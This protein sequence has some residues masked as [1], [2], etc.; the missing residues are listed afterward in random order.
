MLNL[1]P[2]N[3]RAA[4]CAS[5]PGLPF[6]P[7]PRG[8]RFPLWTCP[9]TDEAPLLG[10]TPPPP[11]FRLTER[12][13]TGPPPPADPFLHRKGGRGPLCRPRGRGARR[14]EKDPGGRRKGVV[15]LP[16]P[17][18]AGGRPIH[19]GWFPWQQEGEGLVVALPR[20][21][22]MSVKARRVPCPPLP[23]TDPAGGSAGPRGGGAKRRRPQLPR[24]SP[25]PRPRDPAHGPASPSKLPPPRP[26]APGRSLSCPRNKLPPVA[27]RRR[28]GREPSPGPP[29]ALRVLAKGWPGLAAPQWGHLAPASARPPPSPARSACPPA[30]PPVGSCREWPRSPLQ[31]APETLS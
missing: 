31:V 16:G 4:A 18:G 21:P 17:D 22:Q 19:S 28:P 7:P 27:E 15:G 2:L 30:R 1:A 10:E 14:A 29:G 8:A 23:G 24:R 11:G 9:A 26:A 13:G 6:L 25:S 12:P 3:K 5:S 20:Q